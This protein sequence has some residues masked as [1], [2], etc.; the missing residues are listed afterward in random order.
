M[1]QTHTIRH[2]GY[3]FQ[4]MSPQ[5]YY[6]RKRKRRL[7]KKL[8]VNEFL[9]LGYFIRFVGEMDNDSF[10]EWYDKTSDRLH[11]AGCVG[12]CKWHDNLPPDQKLS[13]RS[14]GFGFMG[15]SS[16]NPNQWGGL[17]VIEYDPSEV[18]KEEVEEI[19]DCLIGEH[20]QEMN[21]THVEIVDINQ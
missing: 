14:I 15:A 18:S 13:I 20:L 10:N 12:L 17:I 3:E 11:L 1:E 7:R 19:V 16:P 21:E 2:Q 5:S 9:E 6:N 8:K 4:S